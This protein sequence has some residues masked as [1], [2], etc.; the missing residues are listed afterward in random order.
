MAKVFIKLLKILLHTH[1]VINN[2]I[3]IDGPSIKCNSQQP[4]IVEND[5]ACVHPQA[6]IQANFV[7][8]Q[9]ALNQNTQTAPIDLSFKQNPQ[10]QLHQQQQQHSEMIEKYISTDQPSAIIQ[11]DVV[12]NLTICNSIV[13]DAPIEINQPSIHPNSQQQNTENIDNDNV[14]VGPKSICHSLQESKLY[15]NYGRFYIDKPCFEEQ[16]NVV[17][18][19][20]NPIEDDEIFWENLYEDCSL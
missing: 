5:T 19:E 17:S 20:L 9:I 4:Q 12:D 7:N 8:N 14:I 6:P 18:T 13:Q 16:L 2:S 10:N 3:K 11:S 15:D 1:P